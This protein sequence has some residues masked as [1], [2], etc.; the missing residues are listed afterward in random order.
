VGEIYSP[1]YLFDGDELAERPAIEDAPAE[2]PYGVPFGIKAPGAARAVLVAP[3]ATTHGADM[4]QR[5][6]ELETVRSVDGTGL[7]VRS[8]T[9]PG[10]APPGYYMLFVL[11]ADGTPSIARWVRV[12]DDAP[13]PE[14]LHDPEPTPTA[15]PSAHPTVTADPLPT[16]GPKCPLPPVVPRAHRTAPRATVSLVRSGRR[17]NV[18][19][20]LS[21]KGRAAIEIRYATRKVKRTLAFARANSTRTV[22]VTPPRGIRKLTVTV[23]ARDAAGNQRTATTRW[24]AP[25]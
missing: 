14:T 8:P 20:K 21:E 25:S 22:T 9:G 4:N 7:D 6:I 2:L 12:H 17:L 15:S 19:L 23:K 3:G 11:D 5:L 16:P 24:S 13:L 1:P 10:A 18:R